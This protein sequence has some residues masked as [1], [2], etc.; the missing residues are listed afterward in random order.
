M[1]CGSITLASELGQ[2]STFT[3]ILPG[4]KENGW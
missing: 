3:L 1:L 2:G 4:Q